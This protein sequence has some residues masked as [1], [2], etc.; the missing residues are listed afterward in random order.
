MGSPSSAGE[1]CS[2]FSHVLYQYAIRYAKHTVYDNTEAGVHASE[3][4]G[5][6]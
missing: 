4:S 6:L 5:A 2:E 3:V 1:L